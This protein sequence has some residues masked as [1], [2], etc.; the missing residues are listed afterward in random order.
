MKRVFLDDK[1][2]PR[3]PWDIKEGINLARTLYTNIVDADPAIVYL[4]GGNR[5]LYGEYR[6]CTHIDIGSLIDLVD[7]VERENKSAVVAYY[8]ESYFITAEEILSAGRIGWQLKETERNGR[9]YVA[10]CYTEQP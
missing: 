9:L 5:V 10:H 8:A 1:L 7:I 2:V 4:A 6:K 3:E